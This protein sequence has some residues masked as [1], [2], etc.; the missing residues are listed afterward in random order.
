[1]A[2]RSTDTGSG[3]TAVRKLESYRQQRLQHRL[4]LFPCRMRSVFAVMC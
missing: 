3:L 1:M 4:H 2:D